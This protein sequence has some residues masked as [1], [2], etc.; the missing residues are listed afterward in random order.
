MCAGAFLY[1]LSCHRPRLPLSSSRTFRTHALIDMT[2]STRS[3]DV[4]YVFSQTEGIW[5]HGFMGLLV[6]LRVTSSHGSTRWVLT[7]RDVP[8]S[9]I[10][11]FIFI[12]LSRPFPLTPPISYHLPAPS[13]RRGEPPFCNPIA[14]NFVISPIPF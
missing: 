3:E 11:L 10:L 13:H 14:E 5:R 8:F 4:V 1:I 9:A 6:S 7:Q 12:S 2:S